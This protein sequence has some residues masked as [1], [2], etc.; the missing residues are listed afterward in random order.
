MSPA[1]NGGFGPSLGICEDCERLRKVRWIEL[2]RGYRKWLCERCE[3]NRAEP[4]PA[5]I[6]DLFIPVKPGSDP[7]GL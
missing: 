2:W 4:T 6:D 1:S 5:S 3:K 7:R